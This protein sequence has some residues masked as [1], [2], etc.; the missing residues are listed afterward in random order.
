MLAIQQEGYS[1]IE[2]HQADYGWMLDFFNKIKL[3]SGITW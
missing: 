3:K 2:N 1:N